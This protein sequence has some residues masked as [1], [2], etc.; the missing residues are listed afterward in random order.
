MVDLR[1]GLLDQAKSENNEIVSV[2]RVPPGDV[3]IAAGKELLL[4]SS[5]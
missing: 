2:F 3:N 5:S 1:K 4:Q